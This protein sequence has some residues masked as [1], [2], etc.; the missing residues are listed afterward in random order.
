M[1]SSTGGSV[2]TQEHDKVRVAANLK[3]E[4]KKRRDL[5]PKGRGVYGEGGRVW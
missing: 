1:N 5:A 3:E 2:L 4:A